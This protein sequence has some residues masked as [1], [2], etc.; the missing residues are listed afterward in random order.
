M[1]GG[2][3]L[4]ELL[5]TALITKKGR[6]FLAFFIGIAVFVGYLYFDGK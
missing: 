2:D 6:W 1:D 4:G 3:M 5:I